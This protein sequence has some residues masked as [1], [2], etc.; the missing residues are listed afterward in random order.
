MAQIRIMSYAN[1]GTG[2]G[3][4]ANKGEGHANK[5]RGLQSKHFNMQM[6]ARYANVRIL[7]WAEHNYANEMDGELVGV[8]QMR[9]GYAN[10]G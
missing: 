3:R 10:L 1:E 6:R 9:L 5:G 7:I 2:T 8:M 4:Y